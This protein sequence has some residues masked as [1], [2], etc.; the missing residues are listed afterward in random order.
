MTVTVCRRLQKTPT[1]ENMNL[2]LL[3]GSKTGDEG[4]CRRA[5]FNTKTWKSLLRSIEGRRAPDET[6]AQSPAPYTETKAR[7]RLHNRVRLRASGSNYVRNTRKV[8]NSSG[9]DVK[10]GYTRPKNFKRS[11]ISS[12]WKC[13]YESICLAQSGRFHIA[14]IVTFRAFRLEIIDHAGLAEA[15]K[16]QNCSSTSYTPENQKR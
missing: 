3:V 6:R 8:E 11:W 7:A 16:G 5:L 10:I 2:R 15:H 13:M 4:K 14:S 12:V 9:S 1:V